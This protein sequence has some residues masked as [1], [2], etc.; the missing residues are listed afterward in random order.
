[1]P[2]DHL[3]RKIETVMDYEWPYE[4]HDPLYCHKNGR[5]STDPVV[6]GLR[7]TGRD[8]T[9]RPVSYAFCKRFPEELTC[10][11]F[12][13]ILDK[14]LNN[15]RVDPSVIFIDGTHIKASSNNKK[16]QKQKV[17]EAAK[18]HTGKIREEENA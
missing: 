11:I 10:E 16:F 17:A 18:V 13:H 4:R 2:K 14:A 8:P 1:M 9:L 3:H 6:S 7:F 12:E 5:R 15:R